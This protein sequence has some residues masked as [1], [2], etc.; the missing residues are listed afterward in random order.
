MSRTAA[1]RAPAGTR[2]LLIA[3]ASS[4]RDPIHPV[5]DKHDRGCP[6]SEEHGPSGRQT[7][8]RS[9]PHHAQEVQ[10]AQWRG[11]AGHRCSDGTLATTNVTE[12]SFGQLFNV[13]PTQW[14]IRVERRLAL[15]T[16]HA[17]NCRLQ[18]DQPEGGV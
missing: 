5:A 6:P 12:H 18:L 14:G 15:W 4:Q 10:H 1:N 9:A 8:V 11:M 16:G 7:R 2:S 3:V 17:P 13:G